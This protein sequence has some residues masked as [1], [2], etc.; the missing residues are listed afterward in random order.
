MPRVRQRGV[1][2]QLSDFERGRV[3]GLREGGLSVRD[4]AQRIGRSVST[5]SRCWRRWTEGQEQRRRIRPGRPRN[6]TEREDRALRLAAVRDRFS[7]TRAIGDIW[8]GLTNLGISVRSVYRR[9]HSFGLKSYR[10]FLCLPLT[11]RHKRSRLEWCNE[12]LQW[13]D[14]WK[15]VVFSDESRFCLCAHDGRK[16]VRRRRGERRNLQFAVDRHTALTRGVMLWGAIGYGSKSPLV[17]IPGVLNANRYIHT[18][19]EPTLIP[20]LRR[21]EN[22]IFQQDNARPHVARV[23]MEFL[24]QANVDLLPWPSRSP[25]LSPIEHVWDVIGRRLGHLHPPPLTLPDIRMRIQEAWDAI[26]QADI[27]N[28][29]SSMPR[30]VAECCRNHGGATHY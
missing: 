14:Q 12:R 28:L 27:D 15:Q 10:P 26:P 2:V 17:F 24:E 20:Y 29:I 21:L 18:V 22:P 30:R 13:V 6:T 23:T 16:M 5:I 25:D 3:I 19:L 4:I 9:I 8:R 11:P 1:F 7:T